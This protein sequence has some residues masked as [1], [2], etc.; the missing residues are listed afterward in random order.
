MRLSRVFD[1]AMSKAVMRS[2]LSPSK[3]FVSSTLNSVLSTSVCPGGRF[4]M[5]VKRS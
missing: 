3:N 4:S 5:S 2:S 1:S